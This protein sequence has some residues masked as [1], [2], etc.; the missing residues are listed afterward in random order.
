LADKNHL[1]D[2][3]GIRYKR[4]KPV[5]KLQCK[6]TSKGCHI[7]PEYFEQ[8]ILDLQEKGLLKK[9]VFAVNAYTVLR[10][11]SIDEKE[12]IMRSWGPTEYRYREAIEIE[13]YYLGE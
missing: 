11:R 6:M 10:R 3:E 2:L 13:L 9:G 4:K 1:V 7:R 12:T 8:Q 5:L